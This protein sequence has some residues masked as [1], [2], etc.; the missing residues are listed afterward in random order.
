[1]SDSKSSGRVVRP[2]PPGN[3]VDTDNSRNATN[4]VKQ[5]SG[6]G[7]KLDRYRTRLHH[8]PGCGD[9]V[10]LF[11]VLFD[12]DIVVVLWWIQPVRRSQNVRIDSQCR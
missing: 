11:L 2:G 8:A 12:G 6:S 3:T 5:P 9:Y 4:A 10:V 1:M 7:Q